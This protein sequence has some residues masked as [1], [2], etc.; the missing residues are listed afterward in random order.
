M[1]LAQTQALLARLFT[2]D[3]LRREFFEAP[4]A[5]ATRFGLSMH[6]TQRLAAIDSREIEAF[7]QSLTGKRAL[8]ARRALPLTARALGDRFDALFRQAIGGAAREATNRS[9]AV[10]LIAFLDTRV[11]KCELG[12]RWVA[13]LAR[14]ELAFIDA[15]RS[16]GTLFFRAF[17]FNVASVARALARGEEISAVRRKTFG[18][19]A[20]APRGR[21]RWRLFQP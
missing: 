5:V 1:A 17:D 4:I 19:W 8:Y 12:P 16:G 13:D 6:D 20:R 15:G 7:A 10:A 11:A 3:D 21:L 9:D 18:V 2:D 14:F